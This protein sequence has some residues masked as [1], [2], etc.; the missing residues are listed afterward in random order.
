MYNIKD[1]INMHG[2]ELVCMPVYVFAH[3]Y[4]CRYTCDLLTEKCQ[5]FKKVLQF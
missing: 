5:F 3:V 1:L 2:C 4:I